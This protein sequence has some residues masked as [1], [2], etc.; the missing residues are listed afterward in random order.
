MF[1]G[2]VFLFRYTA[3]NDILVKASEEMDG[4]K[5]VVS[6]KLSSIVALVALDDSIHMHTQ[7]LRA[8]THY[9]KV[10]YFTKNKHFCVLQFSIPAKNCLPAPEHDK[11]W[12]NAF[13]IFLGE[14]QTHCL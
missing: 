3:L 5:V 9:T 12:R 6:V 1:N 8:H 4:T 14:F 2:L 11:F 10:L 7:K 13:N